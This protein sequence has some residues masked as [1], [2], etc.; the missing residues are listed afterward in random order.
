M[1]MLQYL[2]SPDKEKL[3]LT[4]C[5]ATRAAR[6]SQTQS[7]VPN[8]PVW[9]TGKSSSH[10]RIDLRF[11]QFIAALLLWHSTSAL[12][13]QASSKMSLL[14]EGAEFIITTKDEIKCLGKY[15]TFTVNTY[16]YSHVN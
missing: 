5:S 14:L 11:P 13:P 12:L 15:A 16:K 9:P 2:L 1:I 8:K 7:Q 10:N 3:L 6:F 4:I